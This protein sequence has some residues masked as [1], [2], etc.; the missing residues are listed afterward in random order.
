MQSRELFC[1]RRMNIAKDQHVFESILAPSLI[2]RI[3]L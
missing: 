2:N 1:A 3:G